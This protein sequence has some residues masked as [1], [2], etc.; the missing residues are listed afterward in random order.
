MTQDRDPHTHIAEL[1]PA[2]TSCWQS[3]A[4]LVLHGD[5]IYY[6]TFGH[7]YCLGVTK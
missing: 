5:R 4:N 7:L 2:A 1:S 3:N 6:R